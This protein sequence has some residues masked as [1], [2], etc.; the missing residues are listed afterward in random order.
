MLMQERETDVAYEE[1]MFRCILRGDA[2]N[3]V[4]W[5]EKGFGVRIAGMC[6]IR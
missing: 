5:V 4:E 3:L 1:E 2:T 6:C